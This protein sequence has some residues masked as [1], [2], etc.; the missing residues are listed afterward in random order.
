MMTPIFKVA[1]GT[2]F[3]QKSK[4]VEQSMKRNKKVVTYVEEGSTC[5]EKIMT[6]VMNSPLERYIF[7]SGLLSNVRLAT[8]N[9]ASHS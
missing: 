1:E 5:W 6:S 4:I 2:N 3:R 9:V 7:P 8:F